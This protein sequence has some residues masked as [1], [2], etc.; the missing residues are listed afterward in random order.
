MDRKKAKRVSVDSMVRFFLKSYDIPTKKDVDKIIAHIDRLEKLVLNI[1]SLQDPG[2]RGTAQRGSIGQPR[3]VVT[4][5]DMVLDIT[6]R[7]RRGVSFKDIQ[8]QTGFNE[9]KIRNIIY[10]L[11]KIGKIKRIVRGIYTA[12]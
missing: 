9:K 4:A 10:R 3:S 12:A 8:S 7:N 11:D 5:T 2:L 6:K 1:S